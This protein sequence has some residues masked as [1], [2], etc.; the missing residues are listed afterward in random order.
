MK[1]ASAIKNLNNTLTSEASMIYLNSYDCRINQRDDLNQ[2][3]LLSYIHNIQ[4]HINNNPQVCKN[5]TNN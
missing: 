5:Y 1:L 2:I 3:I 4:Y